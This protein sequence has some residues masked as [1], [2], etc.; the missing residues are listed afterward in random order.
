M[1][2]HGKQYFEGGFKYEKS[3]DF[4]YSAQ[5]SVYIGGTS[6][7]DVLCRPALL[8]IGGL[9]RETNPSRSL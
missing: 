2:P 5:H 6:P 9:K 1:H 8:V 4:A 7:I 3:V